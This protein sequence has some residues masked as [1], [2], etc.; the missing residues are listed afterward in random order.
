MPLT[1]KVAI[2]IA[3]H[4]DVMT[5]PTAFSELAR[6]NSWLDPK[7][8]E[9]AKTRI[10][11]NMPN[12]NVYVSVEDLVAFLIQR[13]TSLDSTVTSLTHELKNS[14]HELK[15]SDVRTKRIES[16]NLELT[17]KLDASDEENARIRRLFLF[18]Q[19]VAVFL[20]NKYRMP[21][22]LK[23]DFYL[24]LTSG[25]VADTA[26]LEK[27][28][29][30]TANIGVVTVSNIL[31][32][33]PL[34]DDRHSYAHSKDITKVAFITVVKEMIAKG[35]LSDS[36]IDVYEKVFDIATSYFSAEKKKTEIAV[37]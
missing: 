19:I 16:I 36:P 2:A 11:I 35:Q 17:Q 29:F 31:E 12:T 20:K 25:S 37:L 34:V 23:A 30:I 22:N 13:I 24:K 4:A 3:M 33:L 26:L 15:N 8:T 1:S 7:L 32:W 21:L 27:V 28:Q 9:S 14:N 6:Q 10:D 18:S 5:G